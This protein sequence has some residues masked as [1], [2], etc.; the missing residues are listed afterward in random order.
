MATSNQV[1]D[2]ADTEISQVT[3]LSSSPIRS[4]LLWAAFFP[5]ALFGLLSILAIKIALQK[6][7]LTL[8]EQRN[9]YQAEKVSSM[10]DQEFADGYSF[11][12]IDWESILHQVNAGELTSIYLL[13]E[14]GTVFSPSTSKGN[15][16]KSEIEF[17]SEYPGETSE[18]AQIPSTSEQVVIALYENS[19]PAY[20][21]LLVEPWSEIFSFARGYQ[22]LLIGLSILAIAFSLLML[23]WTI[24]RILQ[25]IS[26]LTDRASKAVPG[27]V[28]RPIKETGPKEIRLLIHAFNLMVIRLSKQQTSLRQYA[29]KALLSQEEERQRLS[30]ELHDVTLQDLIGLHQRIDLIQGELSSDP[31]RAI[32]RL[33]EIEQLVN[34]SIEDVR[35]ISIALRPP[36]LEDLGLPAAIKS[37]CKQMD[38]NNPILS[39]EFSCSGDS[40]RLSADME[41]A[42]YRVVQESLRNIQKHVPNATQVNVDLLYGDNDLKVNVSNDGVPFTTQDIQAFVKSGHLGLA[43]MFERARLFGGSLKIR[44]SEGEETMVSLCFPYEHFTSEQ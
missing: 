26:L 43:G 39:C 38:Q 35:N 21:I 23:S 44:S 3:D 4:Q 16:S 33:N 13:T 20:K 41:L 15:I 36:I 9:T 34:H 24:Q 29:H 40:H 18:L 22:F 42:V 27:S 37:L 32:I 6:V 17:L 1:F 2:D 7:T 12:S 10:V 31:K 28:F 14:D 5:L 11:E 8:A 19:D 25:P 30:M